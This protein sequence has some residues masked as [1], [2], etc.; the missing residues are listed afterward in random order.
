MD[1]LPSAVSTAKATDL[2]GRSGKKIPCGG[3]LAQVRTR[4]RVKEFSG[5]HE[6]GELIRANL[7][8][9]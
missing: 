8:K 6:V 9:E 4:D 1:V 2:L 7:T 3:K 5:I